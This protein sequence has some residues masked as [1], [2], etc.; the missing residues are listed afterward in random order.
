LKTPS[1]DKLAHQLICDWPSYIDFDSVLEGIDYSLIVRFYLWDKVGRALRIQ[2]GIDYGEAS[3]YEEE[4]NKYPFYSTPMYANGNHRKRLFSNK[5][6]IFIPFQTYHTNVLIPELLKYKGA[7]VVSKQETKVLP[8]QNVIK[9][10]KPIRTQEYSFKLFNAIIA[11]LDTKGVR[12]ID[13]DLALLE[14]QIKGTI[15]ISAL[16]QRE[17]EKVNPNLLYVPSDNH[18]PFINY[19]LVANEM[20]IPTLTYQHG[21]DCEHY[22]LD[23]CFAE[24][25]AVW[26]ENRR[27]R[28]VT[29]S[30]FQPRN[31]FTI[32]NHLMATPENNNIRSPKQTLLFITRPH[33]PIKCYAPSRN[34]REGLEIFKILLLFLA[35]NEDITLLVKL[36]PMDLE[37]LYKNE[38]ANRLI[39]ERVAFTN[40]KLEEIFPNVSAVITE[41]ST[42]GAESM[43]YHLPCV[44]AHLAKSEPVLPFA[45][46]NAALP[47]T[48]KEEILRSLATVFNLSGEEYDRMIL[49]QEKFVNDF[50]PTGSVQ[51]LATI[52]KS[53]L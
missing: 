34:Y 15:E 43:R 48:D 18:P 22:Y 33:R 50:L 11:S 5:K 37:S 31:Y 4:V 12:L 19:V 9:D 13:V 32:G 1:L 53:L 6:I 23:D 35:D 41:D 46:Y 40:K 51:E 7:K 30:R 8:S 3:V 38:I 14:R 10:K 21:L 26:S 52:I 2:N 44:H 36:H 24:N 49:G 16:A 47:G 20:G 28:Y 42:A 25:I 27:N 39:K 29:D 17:L 45:S